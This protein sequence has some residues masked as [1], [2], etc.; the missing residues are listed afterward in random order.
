MTNVNSLLVAWQVKNTLI[1]FGLGL[2]YG[3]LHFYSNWSTSRSKL[4]ISEVP[5]CTYH[6]MSNP[7]RNMTWNQILSTINIFLGV[8]SW[9]VIIYLDVVKSRIQADDPLNPKYKGMIDCFKQCYKEGGFRIFGRGM[10]V[11]SLRAFPL[12]GATFLGWVLLCLS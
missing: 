8:I 10:F 9:I 6:Q 4:W 7:I 3:T 11:M 2:H 1:W 12:N 5:K